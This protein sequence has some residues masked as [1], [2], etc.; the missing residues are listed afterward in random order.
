MCW[1]STIGVGCRRRC[2]CTR[3]RSVRRC[4]ATVDL[5]P[6]TDTGWLIADPLGLAFLGQPGAKKHR[7]AYVA[8]LDAVQSASLV[9]HLF[10]VPENDRGG[11]LCRSCERIPSRA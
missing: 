7:G 5:R 8:P 1:P 2:A 3:M 9:R 11:W 6:I 10:L 4:P